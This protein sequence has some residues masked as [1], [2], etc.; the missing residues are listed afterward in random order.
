M[1]GRDRRNVPVGLARGRDRFDAWRKT[2]RRG[3]RIPDRLW[4]LAVKLADAHGL[5]RTASVLGLDYYALK[6]RVTVSDTQAQSAT[7]TFVELAPPSVAV[8]GEC[9]IEFEDGTGAIMRV[10]LKGCDAPDVVALSR[11]FWSGR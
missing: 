4:N 5:N 3:A 1:S 2:R 9:S 10:Y 6:K 7:A 11:S 8:S